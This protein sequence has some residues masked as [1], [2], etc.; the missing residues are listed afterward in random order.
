MNSDWKSQ[1][2][3]TQKYGKTHQDTFMFQDL[4]KLKSQFSRVPQ[5]SRVE[6]YH[7][8]KL[9][10]GIEFVYRSEIDPNREVQVGHHIAGMIHPEV[11]CD[12]LTLE[13]DEEILEK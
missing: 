10:F 4:D 8:T 5:V 3:V 9:V 1:V 11:R 6:L 12:S 13:K 2:Q 7:D